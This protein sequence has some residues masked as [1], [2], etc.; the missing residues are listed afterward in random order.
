MEAAAAVRQAAKLLPADGQV[1][2]DAGRLCLIDKDFKGAVDALEAAAQYLP[3]VPQVWE[4][5]GQARMVQEEWEAAVDDFWRASRL[6]PAN[7]QLQHNIGLASI[8]LGQHETAITV[9]REVADRLPDDLAVQES[10]SDALE[11]AGWWSEAALVR[12]KAAQLAQGDPQRTLAWARTAR[13]ANDLAA[14]QEALDLA[15]QIDPQS[16]SLLLEQALLQRAHRD[17]AGAIQS[18]QELIKDCD[19]PDLLQPAGE[20]LIDLGQ[21]QLAMTAFG[22]LAELDPDDPAGQV[23]L[24]QLSA[25]MGNKVQALASYQKAV[26]L[27]PTNPAYQ[28]A[29]AQ[30]YWD[31]GQYAQAA[32]AWETALELQPADTGTIY[33]LGHVYARMGDPAAAL[34]MFEQ[35]AALPDNPD[36]PTGPAWR[37]A[38]RSALTLGELSK[39]CTCLARALQQLPHDPET[40][41]LLGALAD[42]LGKPEEALDAYREAAERAPDV[43]AYQLQ[44]ADALSQRGQDLDAVNI[45]EKILGVDVQA[46]TAT[47]MLVQMGD[48]YARAGRYQDAERVLRQAL[49]QSPNAA[50]EI[51]AQLASVLVEQAERI[52]YQQRA[53][54]KVVEPWP[55]LDQAVVWLAKVE[56]PQGQRD[57][58]RARLLTGRVNEAITGLSS[59][60]SST[61][62]DLSAQRALG[63]AYRPAGLLERSFDVLSTALR[64][65]PNDAR[66]T[67]ELAQTYVAMGKP[68]TAV[69]L[70]DRLAS[71]LPEQAIVLYH[72]AQ[73]HEAVGDRPAAIAAL[74]QAVDCQPTVANWLGTLSAWL[75]GHGQPSIALG[76]AESAAELEPGAA[77]KAELAQ[78]MADLGRIKDAI[79]HW[80]AAVQLETDVADWWQTLG[81][82]LLEDGQPGP[83]AECFAQAVQLQPKEAGPYQGGAKAML[84]LGQ[85]DEAGQLARKA[86]ELAPDLPAAHACLGEWQAANGEWHHALA[87]FQKAIFQASQN[88]VNALPAERAVYL[89][90]IARAYR[91]LGSHEQA[92]QELERAVGLAPSLGPAYVL[93]GDIHLEQDSRDQARQ[94]YQQAAQADPANATVLL[95][96]AQFLQS[97][98]QLDQALDWLIK[99]VAVR[100]AAELWLAAAEI[101]RQRGQRGKHLEA[102]H[103]AVDLEADHGEALYEL[104]LAYKQRKKYQ[105]AIEAFE[106]V[107][108]LQPNNTKAHK[109]LSAVVAISLAGRISMGDAGQLSAGR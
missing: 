56:T 28:V 64:L 98:G 4:L 94:A 72:L 50:S 36:A 33:Q 48:L 3:Q 99:A 90:Q 82:L 41:S 70:L 22:R 83:A 109:Q 32:Q 13:Q 21:S 20:S 77:A 18:L 106:K 93:M 51:Q 75:R 55:D 14:S 62:S 52:D 30:V 17:L 79:H 69:T 44:L 91:A 39:A 65:A 7:A 81:D 26:D 38:G 37:E 29:I 76:Y 95:Q 16:K 43:R 12:Q 96:L 101:Y 105:M 97:E 11:A 42:Q 66:T 78:V 34:E 6:D 89:L 54:I 63:V 45:W 104:G 68:A 84:S 88:G 40:H 74:H 67:V 86:L 25:E 108:Q 92:L 57:L 60:L 85:L 15:R 27:Q 87:S 31:M 61:R 46:D 8:Y 47:E 5:L 35:A 71:Q 9:L 1:L 73:A 49:D 23:R 103:R 59:Y 102:L 100:P 19:D 58:A 80:Q 24:A 53:A 10:L 107:A 2:L